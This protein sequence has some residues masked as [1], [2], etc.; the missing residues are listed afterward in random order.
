MDT[1]GGSFKFVVGGE[2]EGLALKDGM[3][4]AEELPAVVKIS[5]EATVEVAVSA[6][7][8]SGMTSS[9]SRSESDSTSAEGVDILEDGPGT[10]G[11][12]GDAGWL[13]SGWCVVTS[14]MSS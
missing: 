3:I 10:T 1:L 5:R 9:M 7:A 11:I 4:A 2:G 8:A 14:S 13:A 6:G 12:E